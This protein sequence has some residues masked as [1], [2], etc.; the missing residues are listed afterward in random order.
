MKKQK[1][2]Y[3][4]VEY[5]SQEE[6][7]FFMWIEEGIK[8]GLI[9][10]KVIYQPEAYE[11]SPKQTKTVLK[12]LKTKVKE[13]EKHLFHPH[14]YTADFEFT[15]RVKGLNL[16]LPLEGGKWSDTKI[17]VDV[18]GSFNQHG[19]DRVFSINQKLVYDTHGDYV[20]KVV[21]EKLFK[22]TWCP[23]G[24]RLT[25]KTRQ[26]KKKYAKCKTIEEFLK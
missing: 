3:K 12:Q 6:I 24:A 5:D 8:A 19:G 1:P 7:E 22:S 15:F 4:G 26:I 23:Q 17:V 2:T 13:V 18:K 21:P 25:S 16:N 9:M 10:P 11:L 20:N 14:K